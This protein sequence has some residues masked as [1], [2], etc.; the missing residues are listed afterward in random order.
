MAWKQPARACDWVPAWQAW[1][2]EPGQSEILACSAA[3]GSH[4]LGKVI[5]SICVSAPSPV[6][7][8]WQG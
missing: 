2:D 3:E 1:G 6:S 5:S 7:G 8:V 4:V